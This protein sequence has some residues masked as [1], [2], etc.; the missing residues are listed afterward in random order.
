VTVN[1]DQIRMIDQRIQQHHVRTWSVGTVV[2]RDTTGSGATV[3][4]DGSAIASPVK[5]AGSVFCQP[6]DRVTLH[7]YGSDWVITNTF[8]APGF[9]AADRYLDGLASATAALTSSAF[10]D[11]VE[12]GTFEFTKFHDWT[13]VRVGLACGAYTSAVPG[14]AIWAVRLTAITGGIGH[15]PSDLTLTQIYFN[16]AS[17]HTYGSGFRRLTGIPAGTYTVSLRWRRQSGSG[18]IWSDTANT[19][20][21]EL[22]ERVPSASTVQ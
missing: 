3:Q 18:N 8:A 15:T 6:G 10:I 2:T 11:L 5:C 1:E 17:T 20:S 21:M 14:K 16:Q 22:D 7:R 12:F 19:Y 4:M 13:S 9:G